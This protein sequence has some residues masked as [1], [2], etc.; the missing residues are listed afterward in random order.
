MRL[1][2][3]RTSLSLV[4]MRMLDRLLKSR[5]RSSKISDHLEFKTLITFSLAGFSRLLLSP[6]KER[7][8]RV[9]LGLPLNIRTVRGL[10]RRIKASLGSNWK[11]SIVLPPRLKLL[12]IRHFPMNL[13]WR[14][15]K[16]SNSDGLFA[17]KMESNGLRKISRSIKLWQ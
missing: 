7:Q 6:Q 13:M 5:N 8:I 3:T 11:R 15:V 1:G 4:S 14:K 16:K 17:L 2:E 12:L 10:V 9:S